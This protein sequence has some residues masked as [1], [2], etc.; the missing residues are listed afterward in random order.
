M[1]T[2]KIIQGSVSEL[3]NEEDIYSDKILEE[4]FEIYD[5][6]E[7]SSFIGKI[8]FEPMYKNFISDIRTYSLEKQKEF[9]YSVLERIKKVYGFEFLEKPNIESQEDLYI[10]YEFIEFLEFNN[11]EFLTEIF[12]NIKN[13][14]EK[15]KTITDSFILEICDFFDK[16]ENKFKNILIN[17]FIQES[18]KET[19]N[20]FIK[21][22]LKK[23]KEKIFLSLKISQ[24]Y[25]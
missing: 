24:L 2:N 4:N 20:K 6:I 8:N 3:E 18:S 23:N 16:I 7:L 1:E 13:S 12:I 11:I 25:I 22:S 14:Y 15:L 5:I 17:K 10:F 9:S 21:I 19:I